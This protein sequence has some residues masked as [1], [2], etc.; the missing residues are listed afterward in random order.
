VAVAAD[1]LRSVVAGERLSLVVAALVVAAAVIVV[2]ADDSD[3]SSPPASLWRDVSVSFGAGRIDV[4]VRL[5]GPQYYYSYYSYYYYNYYY[6]YGG[7]SR[8]I[9][10][11][12][13]VAVE[14]LYNGSLPEL[15]RMETLS[16][17]AYGV[18]HEGYAHFTGLEAGEY[19]V[20]VLFW[21]QLLSV[22]HERGGS[23]RPR[24]S[25]YVVVGNVT[26]GP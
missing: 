19:R 6:Y 12:V 16:L 5:P 15:V 17:E 21:N 25:P 2:A 26:S 10:V 24:A 22:L 18:Y 9:P 1:A 14:R 11:K 13:I 8:A 20:K 4:S 3:H 7:V 23:W